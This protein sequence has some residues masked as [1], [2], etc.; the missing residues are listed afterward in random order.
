MCCPVSRLLRRAPRA[1]LIVYAQRKLDNGVMAVARPTN[2]IEG[3]NLVIWILQE[4]ASAE[5]VSADGG[6]RSQATGWDGICRRGYYSVMTAAP[7]QQCS[8]QLNASTR[9]STHVSRRSTHAPQS[10]GSDVMHYERR[11]SQEAGEARSDDLLQR[12]VAGDQRREAGAAHQRHPGWQGRGQRLR[13]S[14]PPRR[15]Q[16]ERPEARR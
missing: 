10:P 14:P 5:R 9:R 1:R 8:Q 2:C 15:L 4:S 12:A 6:S 3:E 16:L 13:C 11:R 7:L